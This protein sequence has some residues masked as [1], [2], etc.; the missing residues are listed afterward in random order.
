VHNSKILV[1]RAGHYSKFVKGIKFMTLNMEQL[2]K[3]F[4]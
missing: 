3:M 1:Q 2:V 4:L